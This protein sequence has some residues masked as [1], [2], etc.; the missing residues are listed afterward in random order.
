MKTIDDFREAYSNLRD[1]W[2]NRNSTFEQ[3]EKAYANLFYVAFQ[4][5]CERADYLRHVESFLLAAQ[6]EW[7]KRMFYFIGKQDVPT[8]VISITRW[9]K[10]RHYYVTF[11]GADIDSTE[12]FPSVV[13]AESYAKRE[14]NRLSR[15]GY[16]VTSYLRRALRQ[17]GEGLWPTKRNALV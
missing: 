15:Q 4:V 10:G 6:L 14:K 2:G 5:D 16:Q 7:S 8:V 13:A 3:I 17:I 12:S 11:R 9:P 1:L